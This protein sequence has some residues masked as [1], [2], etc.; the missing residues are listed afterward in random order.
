MLDPYIDRLMQSR[1]L[2]HLVFWVA[3]MGIY[4][5]YTSAFYSSIYVYLVNLMALLPSQIMASYLFV[6]YQV[7]KLLEQKKYVRFVISFLFSA[8]LLMALARFLTIYVVE[9]ILERGFPKESIYEI[10]TEPLYLY[11]RYGLVVYFTP[12][13]MLS[14]KRIQDRYQ[15]KQ[16]LTELAKAKTQAELKF[17]KTQIHPHFLF[18]TLNNL[19]VLTLQQ[20]KEAPE[21]VMKLSDMLDY[22]LY[23]CNAPFVHLDKEI[24]LL[25]NYIELERLRYGERLDLQ[26]WHETDDTQ[27]E[28]APMLLLPIVENAFKHGA[29]ADLLQPQI[30]ISLRVAKG[31][32]E[33]TVWN[34]KSKLSALTKSEAREGIGLNN[35]QQQLALLYPQGYQL[36]IEETEDHYQLSLQIDL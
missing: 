22:M 19:Y 24:E 14:L 32:L 11:V 27:A 6:Y 35:L 5:L 7:P 12:F 3:I 29:S 31:E 34:T 16:Q 4:S 9:D 28:I 36:D 20:S 25:H 30:H 8:Y 13:I 33:F 1:F 23:Q 15:E 18:N 26:F 10:L 21:V 2:R 17:L